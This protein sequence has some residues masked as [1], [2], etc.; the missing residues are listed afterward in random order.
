MG[1][2]PLT[3]QIDCHGKASLR[4][5]VM[6]VADHRSWPQPWNRSYYSTLPYQTSIKNS[7]W[8][9]L[10]QYCPTNLFTCKIY[11]NKRQNY[12]AK[13]ILK[14]CTIEHKSK[15][16]HPNSNIFLHYIVFCATGKKG[17]K[18]IFSLSIYQVVKLSK[19]KKQ[20]RGGIYGR[21]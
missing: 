13:I 8:E 12:D 1:L 19:E 20:W 5:I 17:W 9:M 14:S 4:S 21:K 16:E 11:I 10:P 2:Q 7:I 3:F 6:P 18:I 15:R